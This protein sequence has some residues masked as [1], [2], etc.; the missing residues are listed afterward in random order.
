MLCYVCDVMLCYVMLC[1][2]MLRYEGDVM[3]PNTVWH[4]V[5]RGRMVTCT[6][7]YVYLYLYRVVRHGMAHG[8]MAWCAVPLR[9]A[10]LPPRSAPGQAQ[11]GLAAKVIADTSTALARKQAAQLGVA[12]CKYK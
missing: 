7:I 2:V 12:W 4:D 11:L 9:E 8:G 10:A 5:A 1:Y 3:R 6:Y